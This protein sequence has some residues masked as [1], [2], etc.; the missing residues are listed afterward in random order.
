MDLLDLSHAYFYLLQHQSQTVGKQGSK[1]SQTLAG[2]QTQILGLAWENK[3]LRADAR[4][5][6]NR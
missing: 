5:I 3:S 4:C 2:S 1:D 6:R